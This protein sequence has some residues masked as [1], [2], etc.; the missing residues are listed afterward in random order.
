ME[1]DLEQFLRHAGILPA[2][3]P[4]IVDEEQEIPYREYKFYDPR[5]PVTGEVPF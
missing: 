3:H 5:D 1:Y 4:I 2:K